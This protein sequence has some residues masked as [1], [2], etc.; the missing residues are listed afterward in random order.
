MTESKDN[1]LVV[2]TFLG[3]TMHRLPMMVGGVLLLE[4]VAIFVGWETPLICSI[5]AV[6]GIVLVMMG[7]LTQAHPK[8]SHVWMRVAVVAGLLTFLSGG[9]SF[10]GFVLGKFEAPT[11]MQFSMLILGG[12]YTFACIRSFIFARKAG[13]SEA[14]NS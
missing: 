10:R 12:F 9:L 7:F 2:F 14:Q 3:Q 1:S 5:P 13:D 6:F 8:R 4:G 11:W